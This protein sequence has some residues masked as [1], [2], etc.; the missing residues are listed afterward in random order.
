MV[1]LLVYSGDRG[2]QLF[3][4]AFTR[5]LAHKLSAAF[6]MPRLPPPGWPPLVEW[7]P[8]LVFS[9]DGE[10][11]NGSPIIVDDFRGHAL[12]QS[13][14]TIVR[15]CRG[16]AVHVIGYFERS[17]C[18]YPDRELIR[19]WLAKPD[20]HIEQIAIHVRGQGNKHITPAVAYYHEALKG[21]PD[22]PKVLYTDDPKFSL[23]DT[24]VKT[25]GCRVSTSSA[26][27]SFFEIM[28]S[29]VIV[30]TLSTFCWW[31][32]FL[33]DASVVQPEPVSG[34]RSREDAER[35]LGVPGW[36][37]IPVPTLSAPG[38]QN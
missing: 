28:N 3:G 35:Y 32:A 27:D 18:F 25:T 37:L 19:S 4:Y 22:L 29:A 36:K 24:L 23:V 16:K 13:F 6:S 9:G 26:K 12:K 7:F 15:Q 14:E 10:T 30:S 33:S 20:R 21:F 8:N 17:D 34:Y 11:L 2:N 38:V 1:K 5:L 31:A